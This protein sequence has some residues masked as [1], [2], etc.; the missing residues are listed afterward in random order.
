MRKSIITTLVLCGLAS[1][2]MAAQEYQAPCQYTILFCPRRA[3]RNAKLLAG[4]GQENN[5]RGKQRNR[6]DRQGGSSVCFSANDG[7]FRSNDFRA[8][9]VDIYDNSPCPRL[10]N[11]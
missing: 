9:R 5:P 2:A 6:N 11:R 1:G 8:V 3:Y 4:P 10:R 7:I